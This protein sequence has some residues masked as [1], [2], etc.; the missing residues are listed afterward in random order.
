MG[1]LSEAEPVHESA[2]ENGAIADFRPWGSAWAFPRHRTELNN[3]HP[4]QRV[5]NIG[6]VEGIP[7]RM[8]VY[9]E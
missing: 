9:G 2:S 5:D 6:Q 8:R 7:G 4:L 1:G 3:K